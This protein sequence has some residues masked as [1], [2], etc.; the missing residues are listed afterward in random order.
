MVCISQ[1]M[2]S[3]LLKEDI[4]KV[5]YGS[6][7]QGSTLEYIVDCAAERKCVSSTSDLF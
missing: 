1:T 7:E 4:E 6:K 5:E 3:N 2:A